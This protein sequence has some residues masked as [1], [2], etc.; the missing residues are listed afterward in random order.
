M[1]RTFL[2]AVIAL[3]TLGAS[4]QCTPD[5]LYA[6]SIFGVWPDTL[7]NFADGMVGMFY[8]DT[9]NLLI[10]VSAQDIDPGYPA[11]DID[12]VQMTGVSG[13]PPG[14]AIICNSQTGAACTYLPTVLGCG[15]IEGTP[16]TAGSYPMTID[17]LAWFTFFGTAQS[18]PTSF[19]GYEITIAPATA[20]NE[21][22]AAL[23]SG[24]RNTP[25][26]FAGLTNI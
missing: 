25:N 7:E 13:L 24:S 20:I 4:A 15:L 21:V 6:D 11:I 26:P 14:L 10:P 19:T 9:L 8:T 1:K 23:L 3:A 17:V 5:P 12:S 2:S 18:F 22:N 16:T